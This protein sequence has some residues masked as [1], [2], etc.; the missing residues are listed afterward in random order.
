MLW[1]GETSTAVTF[2]HTALQILTYDFKLQRSYVGNVDFLISDG[3]QA[4]VGAQRRLAAKREP[5]SYGASET[6]SVVCYT[7]I[8]HRRAHVGFHHDVTCATWLCSAFF[9]QALCT[10]HLFLMNM[11]SATGC[12]KKIWKQGFQSVR[13]WLFRLRMTAQTSD[14]EIE[15]A[16]LQDFVQRIGCLEVFQRRR[17]DFSAMVAFLADVYSKKHSWCR[18]FMVRKDITM[19]VA[20]SNCAENSFSVLKRTKKLS[21]MTSLHDLLANLASMTVDWVKKKVENFHD[22]RL[23]STVVGDGCDQVVR[24]MY[25]YLHARPAQ[26]FVDEWEA[27]NSINI[28]CVSAGEFEVL[29]PTGDASQAAGNRSL[30]HADSLEKANVEASANMKGLVFCATAVGAGEDAPHKYYWFENEVPW[31][32]RVKLRG[33]ELVCEYVCRDDGTGSGK[34]CKFA[35]CYGPSTASLSLYLLFLSRCIQLFSV[36]PLSFCLRLSLALVC[37]SLLSAVR[38]HSIG[39]GTDYPCFAP[40]LPLAHRN[41]PPYFCSASSF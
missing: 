25:K 7:S 33:E 23:P 4:I 1:L 28:N 40:S 26:A 6:P 21:K 8:V 14:F 41:V 36:W 2:S 3:A 15:W 17:S 32:R 13:K 22:L 39:R 18:A 9:V 11:A 16:C 19:R 24:G 5:W 29:P 12:W 37:V 38:W 31:Y 34:P 27:A 10:V 35:D 20:T 30:V